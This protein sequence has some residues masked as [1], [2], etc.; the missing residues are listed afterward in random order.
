[1]KSKAGT[2]TEFFR[3]EKIPKILLQ[4]APPVMLAQLIQAMY[5]IV[6]SFFVG[7]YSEPALTALS[8]IYPLQLIIIALAVGTGVGVNTYMARL[9]AQKMPG[10]A[11]ETAGTGTLLAL[12]TW[13]IFA[14]FSIFCMRPY[15][16]T[17]ANT[18]EAIESAVIYGQI[19]C[20]GSIGAFLEGNWTKVHQSRGNMHRPM[21]AQTVGALTNIMLDPILIFGLGP[22]PELGVAGAAYATVCGQVAAAVI[23]SFGGVGRLPER[24][25]MPLYI[26]QIYW[27]GYASIIMQALFTVYIVILNAIL[28]GFSDSAVTVLGL[29]YK[30]QTFFFI[31]LMGLQTCIATIRLTFSCEI[32]RSHSKTHKTNNDIISLYRNRIAFHT[33]T[34]SGSCLTGN[35]QVTV[36]YF[37]WAVQIYQSTHCKHNRTR[38]ALADTVTQSPF[39]VGVCQ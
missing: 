27:F 31:P 3:T 37:Q 10:Q 21:V 19:V 25:K 7:K 13:F 35:C 15:V 32:I 38:S 36:Y 26:K 12:G 33:N 4:I 11:E 1:M 6:D 5:N 24:T 28:A 16:L 22:V 23:T 2:D 18:P 39:F 14:I 20:I 30:M 8:V 9:Y 29:Y 34:V 17:S